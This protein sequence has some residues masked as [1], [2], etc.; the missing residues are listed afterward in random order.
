MK[1]N[2][3]ILSFLLVCSLGISQEKEIYNFSL[4]GAISFALDS[5]YTAIN[6]RRDIAKALKQKW[7]TTARGLPQIDASVDYTNMLEQPVQLIPGEFIGGEI[8]ATTDSDWISLIV[9]K[10]SKKR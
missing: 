9:H 8:T 4:E 3:L 6:S 5:S 2:F 7:E 10:S 1:N